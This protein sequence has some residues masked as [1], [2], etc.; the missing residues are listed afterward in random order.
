MPLRRDLL[1]GL[2]HHEARD[3]QSININN[4]IHVS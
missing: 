4:F 1:P 3:C 2:F